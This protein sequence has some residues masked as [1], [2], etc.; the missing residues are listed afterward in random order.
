[1]SRKNHFGRRSFVCGSFSLALASAAPFPAV[2]QQTPPTLKYP[3][4][5]L[6]LFRQMDK[7]CS[8]KAR[9]FVAHEAY[10][11]VSYFPATLI[12]RRIRWE[13][14]SYM[15]DFL[16]EA[17]GIFLG[18]KSD[19]G[20][21]VRHINLVNSS[22]ASHHLDLEYVDILYREIPEPIQNRLKQM[23]ADIDDTKVWVN[24]V[25]AVLKDASIENK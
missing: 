2:S 3:P 8:Q 6:D 13:L 9:S 10:F 5:T 18:K 11:P 24:W 19:Y 7:T 12:A 17:V 1:M 15:G 16:T 4:I 25:S 21:V 20:T 14:I 23:A 22:L